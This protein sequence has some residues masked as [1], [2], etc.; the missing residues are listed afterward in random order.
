MAARENLKPDIPD[1]SYLWM[2]FIENEGKKMLPPKESLVRCQQDAAEVENI[3]TSAF[4]SPGV[5]QP[6][7]VWAYL[8]FQPR[9][10]Q[11]SENA[12]KASAQEFDSFSWL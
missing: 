8:K 7:Q 1:F 6:A 9:Q 12:K 5:A 2:Q 3:S 4:V 11:G 10:P